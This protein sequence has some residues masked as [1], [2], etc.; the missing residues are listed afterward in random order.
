DA[1]ISFRVSENL[2]NGYG[3]RWNVDERVQVFTNPLWMFTMAAAAWI[4]GEFFYTAVVVSFLFC[5]TMLYLIWRWLGRT[6]DGWLV[7]ALLLSSKAFI[8]YSSSGLEYPIT[9]FLLAAFVTVVLGSRQ[10]AAEPSSD[11]LPLLILI[12]SLAFVNRA[13]MILL[14][15]PALLWFVLRRVRTLTWRDVRGMV[16]AS[17]PAWGWLLFAIIYYG[18]PFPNTYYAKAQSGMPDWLQLRQGFAYVASSLRFDPISIATIV[19]AAGAAWVAGGTRARLLALGACIY[20]LY[21][22]RV[23]GDFMAGRF[24]AAPFLMSAMLFGYLPKKRMTALAATGLIVLWNVL[25]PLAPI[26]SS[27]DLEMGWNWRLQNGVKDDR[28]ATAGGVS[29]LT[30]E[31]FRR[32]PDNAMAREARTLQASPDRV[33]VHPWIGEV[34]FW[35]GPEKYV[36]DPNALSDPLLARLPIPPSFYYEFWVSHF[37]RELPSGYVESRRARKNLIEDPLIRAYFDKILRVTTGPVFSLARF[38]DIYDLNVGM[39]DFKDQVKAQQRLNTV[40]RVTN[41]LFWSHVGQ[42]DQRVSWI[43]SDGRQGYLLMG[44]GTPLGPGTFHVRWHGNTDKPEKT[45]LGFVEVCYDDCRTLLARNP[46]RPGPNDLLG[47]ATVR[48]KDEAR[49]VEF[50]LWVNEQSGV[51]VWTVGIS[52]EAGAT[53]N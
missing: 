2:I 8:D 41:P 45:D 28:G 26:K 4:T 22:V 42:L 35:A 32:M 33:I 51:N 16:L 38:R 43:R 20:V 40:V 18:F 1:Y 5:L 11:R 7:L 53:D 15:L 23:G 13:D 6:A 37:T 10:S 3:P 44:P 17:S 27:P 9:Y 36:I 29:P 52:Q 25:N 47:E 46:L 21:T 30:F 14:Y 48:L 39:R 12:A 50:R 49:D 34:G 19:A 24:F 31:I